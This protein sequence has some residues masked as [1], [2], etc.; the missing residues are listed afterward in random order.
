MH[1]VDDE[2]VLERALSNKKGTTYYVV[3][4]SEAHQLINIHSKGLKKPNRKSMVCMVKKYS[5]YLRYGH[6]AAPTRHFVVLRRVC[7]I[8]I[9]YLY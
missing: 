1:L 6:W 7:F 3:L 4:L 8:I 2:T 9:K 5:K